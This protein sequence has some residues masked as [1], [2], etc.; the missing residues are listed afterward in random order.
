MSAIS[1]FSP[2]S[3]DSTSLLNFYTAQLQTGVNNAVAEAS[4]SA[5][6]LG[7]SQGT[8][9]SSSSTSNASNQTPP[10][11]TP[12]TL[13]SQQQAA[14]ILGTTNFIQSSTTPLV[15]VSGAAKTTA[16]DNQKL[17]T[18]WQ[19]VNQLSQLAGLAT[20]KGLTAGQATG[21][22]TRFQAGLQQVESYIGSTTF[23]NLT[24]QAQTPSASTTGKAGVPLGS[25][26]YQGSTIVSDANLS[27]ALT[28]VSSSQSFN[29]A[30]TKGGATTNVAID[31]SQISGPLTLDNIVSYANQQLAAG[32]F[33]S[34]LSRVMTEGTITDIQKASYG[35]AI[36]P[37]VGET[38]NLSSAQATPALYL[39]GTTGSTTGTVTTTSTGQTQTS[40]DNQG[41][42]TKL[43][44]LATSPTSQF[45]T[46][47]APSS[48]NTTAQSTVVDA[49]GN[50]YVV[51]NAT[52]NFGG[53]LNQGTQ[54]VYLSKYDSAG[55][56][57]WSVLLGSAGSASAYSLALNPSTGGVVVSG[58]T[59]ASLTP[60]AVTAGAND[61]FAA[62]YDKNG[63]QL[64]EQ[65]IPAL[66]ANQANAV[67][68][69]ASGNVYIGG[70]V[71][72]SIGTGQTSTGGTNA[73]IA[74][75]SSSGAITSEQ[76]FG[77][78]GND[79][80]SAMATASDGGVLVASVQNGEAFLSK[81]ASGAIT[82]APTWTMD[83]GALNAG[84]AITGLTVSGNN[85][86]VSGTT[87]NGALTAG[88]QA[89]VA[90][91]STGGTNA[92]VFGATDNGSTATANQVS[93][94]GA[95][96]GA[97]S[98]GTV[99]VGPDGTIYLSGTTTGT[100]AGQTRN[101]ANVNN[102]FVT[103]L[104]ASGSIDWTRQFG[105]ADGQS[106]GAA[107]AVSPTGSSVLD[108]LGLP[109]GTININQS[110]SLTS[111]TTVRAGDSFQLQVEGTGGRTSTI[112]INQGETL[113]QLAD[114]INA[115]LL[116]AGKAKVTFSSSGGQS[117]QI[118][119]SAGQTINLI[120]GPK[121]SDALGRLGIKPGVITAAAKKSS[122]NTQTGTSFGVTASSTM[123]S[124]TSS[125]AK[126]VFGLGL[127]TSVDLLTTG[128][129]N[130][131]KITLQSVMT[132]ITQAYQKTNTP[133]S[134]A[135]TTPSTQASGPAPAYLQAQVASYSLALQTLSLAPSIP[136]TT[137]T[138]SSGFG[139]S[140][141]SLLSTLA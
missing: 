71:Q 132:A 8:N 73:Y 66:T 75:L 138:K 61:S 109:T 76:Q 124:S 121:D 84:G 86:Y 70:S 12:S 112:T 97:T 74:Q 37:G 90:S 101:V 99:T 51:G 94:V 92:F 114:S 56:Q 111:Q 55:N 65:Q 43:T 117:L 136:T 27:N 134:S 18:L 64:W 78:S 25:F 128:D 91:A 118:T 95:P 40:P 23:N 53:Q 137:S 82:S 11:A 135:S 58:S 122:A 77:P 105:G 49:Q 57:Q 139:L 100:F 87:S 47:I 69:D 34:R 68:V 28:G 133:A 17:F 125:T 88:G 119:A 20:Q 38:L 104:A 24:L 29:I 107:V 54:D 110:V 140:S 39:A 89:S 96:G 22:N 141:S 67:T 80:V 13:T 72:G 115:E 15:G 1:S 5:Q 98:G 113:Q 63:N 2:I 81:Y 48:G 3:I 79:Q 126:P 103:A 93:Y 120:A 26:D 44:N 60:T 31:L 9:G 6:F 59:T 123:S 21:Y 36:N 131:A 16:E 41:R 7:S 42:L 50:V 35:I 33:T 130:V 52:G 19:A 129:A 116:S 32:G 85:V 45:S 83:L 4:A 108:A 102:A 62:S 46:N 14:Q 30:V 127:S 106:T 10:W